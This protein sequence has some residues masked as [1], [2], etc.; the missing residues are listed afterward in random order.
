MT[1][2]PNGLSRP[3]GRVLRA[4]EAGLYRDAAEALAVAHEALHRARAAA[5]AEIEAERARV[6]NA[7]LVEGQQGASRFLAQVALAARREVEGLPLAIAETIAEGVAKVVGQLAPSEAVARAAAQAVAEL[8]ER[9]G[10]T[11]RVAPASVQAV[12]AHLSAA[13]WNDG[14]RVLGD[15]ALGLRDCTVET[16]AGFV[17]ADLDVQLAALRHALL[18]EARRPGPALIAPSRP[19]SSAGRGPTVSA[20]AEAMPP[21]GPPARSA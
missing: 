19:F 6:C 11:V 13:G 15:P 9:T 3:L 21:S 14:V 2:S 18:Q 16:R 1:A 20:Q 4:G 5:T 10:I 8:S 7:A 12:G 17:R